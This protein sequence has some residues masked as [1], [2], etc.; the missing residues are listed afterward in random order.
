MSKDGLA[1]YRRICSVKYLDLRAAVR[2]WDRELII[3]IL[4]ILR[5]Q[6]NLREISIPDIDGDMVEKMTNRQRSKDNVPF[7]AL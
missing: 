1:R 2:E 5:A 6:N 7:P 3:G 4:G